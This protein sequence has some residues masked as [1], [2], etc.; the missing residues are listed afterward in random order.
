MQEISIQRQ[1]LLVLP[2]LFPVPWTLMIT[3]VV[4]A[5]VCAFLS[6][7]APMRLITAK[8]PVHLLRSL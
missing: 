3:V 7:V 6:S 5:I 4:L 8:S 2:I 1:L